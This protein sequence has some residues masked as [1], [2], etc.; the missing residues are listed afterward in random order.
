MEAK[1]YSFTGPKSGNNFPLTGTFCVL[2]WL[3]LATHPIGDVTICCVS[4]FSK[5]KNSARNWKAEKAQVLRLGSN[6]IHEILNSESFCKIRRQMLA[7]EKPPA[8]WRCFDEEKKG[9]GSKRLYENSNYSDFDLQRARKATEKSGKIRPNLRFVEL[10]LGNTCN[11]KCRTCNPVSSSLWKSEYARLSKDL[12]F[13]DDFDKLVGFG[14]STSS[15]FWDELLD[16]SPHLETLY[17]NGG[18]PT[19]IKKHW[20]FLKQLVDIGRSKNI[21]LWYNT[22]LTQVKEE[23]FQLW[24]KFKNVRL[25]VSIDCLEQRNDYLRYPSQWEDLQKNLKLLR[26]RSLQVEVSQTLSWLNIFYI[27]R[28]YEYMQDLGLRVHFN[29]VHK[30]SFLSPWLLPEEI[31][32][33]ILGRCQKSI[34]GYNVTL[35]EASLKGKTDLNLM[36]RGMMYHRWLDQSRG[37]SMTQS[38]EE[39]F[40]ALEE[41]LGTRLLV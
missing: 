7:S 32:V 16:S 6:S 11:L 14:W 29:P 27:D 5:Q 26:S 37:Q 33:E 22:N 20:D 35:I 38:F 25:D 40:R 9:A 13:V 15:K 31:K 36:N 23:Y 24:E 39:L 8:C 2:P 19:L 21:K 17:I 10:R 4:D 34:L 30:P 28:F 1:G 18:E 3:H 12:D 41:N